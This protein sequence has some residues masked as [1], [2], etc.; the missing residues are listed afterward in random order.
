MTQKLRALLPLALAL[1]ALAACKPKPIR[2][3]TTPDPTPPGTIILSVE[4]PGQPSVSTIAGPVTVTVG[5]NDQV[6][7]TAAGWDQDGG[8]KDIQIWTTTTTWRDNPNGTTRQTGPGLAGRPTASNPSTAQPGDV[9]DDLRRVTHT[10]DVG[11]VRGSANRV[12]VE[13]WAEVHNFYGGTLRS[14]MATIQNF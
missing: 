2:V 13:V 5:A 10:L 9:A 1:V 12:R 11:A 14:N 4:P 3:P 7:L 8:V 6:K